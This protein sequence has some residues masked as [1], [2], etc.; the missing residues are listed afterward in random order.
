MTYGE[1]QTS[2]YLRLPFQHEE[3]NYSE[4]TAQA[5]DDELRGMMDREYGRVRRILEER[6]RELERVVAKLIEKETLERPELEALIASV[7]EPSVR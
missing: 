1:S 3:R 5:I 2:R 6:R 4:Q 7:E